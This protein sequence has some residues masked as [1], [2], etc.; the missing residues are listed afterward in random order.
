MLVLVIATFFAAGGDRMKRVNAAF[1]WHGVI[2]PAN[3]RIDA[4]VSPP[5]YTGK[6]PLILQGLR[7]GEPVQAAERADRGAGRQHAGDPRQRTG[8]SRRIATTGGL[9]GAGTPRRSRGGARCRP[10]GASPS[11]GDGTATVR[12]LSGAI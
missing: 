5:P 3:F 9:D 12:A 2:T 7:P 8:Q 6:P 4:W 11:N 1:D 10:S